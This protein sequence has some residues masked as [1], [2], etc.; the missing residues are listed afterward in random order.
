[1]MKRILVTLALTASV[2]TAIAAC[3]PSNSGGA[4]A[5]AGTSVAPI[6]STD[7]GGGA[8]SGAS[9]GT[10]SSAPLASPSSS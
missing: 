9:T 4:A 1:M 5:T 10:E 7:T 3:S 6:S 2:M 8:S